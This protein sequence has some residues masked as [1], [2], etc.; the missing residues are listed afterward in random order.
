MKKRTN[1]FPSSIEVEEESM[2][3]QGEIGSQQAYST[4]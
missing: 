2:E 4:V 1:Q 3:V